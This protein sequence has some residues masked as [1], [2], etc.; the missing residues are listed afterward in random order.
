MNVDLQAKEILICGL[1]L[2]NVTGSFGCLE[3]PLAGY[4]DHIDNINI[5]SKPSNILSS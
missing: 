5:L 3:D 2:R 1:K 4:Y